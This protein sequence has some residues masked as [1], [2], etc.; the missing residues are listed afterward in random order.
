M[1]VQ[2]TPIP[3]DSYSHRRYFSLPAAGT[4]VLDPARVGQ[5]SV[6]NLHIKRKDGGLVR[7]RLSSTH[8][9]LQDCRWTAA[10]VVMIGAPL[11][12]VVC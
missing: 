1:V 4:S 9:P 5:T 11:D 6:M 10:G 8:L 2:R 12:T 3:G 7:M